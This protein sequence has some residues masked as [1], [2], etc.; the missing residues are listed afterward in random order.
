MAG[1]TDNLGS[2]AESGFKGFVKGLQT[3]QTPSRLENSILT[4]FQITFVIT[5]YNH[6]SHLVMGYYLSHLVKMFSPS[7]LTMVRTLA[8]KQK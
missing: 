1:I 8:K 4:R 3:K 6:N 5:I 2:A 7:E